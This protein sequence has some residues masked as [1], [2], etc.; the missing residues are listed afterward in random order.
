MSH[1]IAG[2]ELYIPRTT[3]IHMQSSGD[4]GGKQIGCIR[5]EGTKKQ[6]EMAGLGHEFVR[7][8]QRGFLNLSRRA[9][10]F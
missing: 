8:G 9:R 6:M 2:L 7:K 3:A 1:Y 4:G 5:E 10:S